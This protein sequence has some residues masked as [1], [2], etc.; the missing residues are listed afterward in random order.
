MLVLWADRGRVTTAAAATEL[1]EGQEETAEA[2]MRV[3]TGELEPCTFYT[4]KSWPHQRRPL[5]V[6]YITLQSPSLAFLYLQQIILSIN[7]NTKV[8]VHP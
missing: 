4:A 5:L 3:G 2:A 8:G 7:Q 6:G 1:Q